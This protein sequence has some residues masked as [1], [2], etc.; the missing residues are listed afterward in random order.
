MFLSLLGS[1]FS[2]KYWYWYWGNGLWA[3]IGI[4]IGID[5]FAP[6]DQYQYQGTKRT[7]NACFK[8]HFL[9]NIAI[10]SHIFPYLIEW[11][12]ICRSYVVKLGESIGIGIEVL[13]FGPVL[14]LV[15][16]LRH[17]R[18]L[19]LVHLV[20]FIR[21]PDFEWGSDFLRDNNDVTI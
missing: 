7:Q 2:R 17:S 10:I 9:A 18:V 3:S 11:D 15:L 8:A 21:S 4:G 6:Q 5:P 13:V 16:T 12:L 14:V 1:D 19:V 20:F